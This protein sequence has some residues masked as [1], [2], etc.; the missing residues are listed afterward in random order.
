MKFPWN[1]YEI[2]MKT[3]HSSA[4]PMLHSNPIRFRSFFST[5]RGPRI[6]RRRPSWWTAPFPLAGPDSWGNIRILRRLRRLIWVSRSIVTPQILAH[7]LPKKA[8]LHWGLP[9][10]NQHGDDLTTFAKIFGTH[11]SNVQA[12]LMVY[13]NKFQMEMIWPEQ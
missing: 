8:G 9:K 2:P 12:A 7:I 5:T 6:P 13:P 3:I 4:Y 11:R 10:P 1:S